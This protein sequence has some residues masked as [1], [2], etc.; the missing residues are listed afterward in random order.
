MRRLRQKPSNFPANNRGFTLVEL[1]LATLISTLVIG[2]L[3][4][5]LAFSLRVWER[6]QNQKPKDIL[7][8]L[9]LLKWQLAQF[10]PEPIALGSETEPIFRGDETSLAFATDYS[11]KAICKGVPAVVR[12][13][14]VPGE[15]A[16]YYAEVPLHPYDPDGIKRFLELRP[17]KHRGWPPFHAVPVA[18][19]SLA[20]IAK[21]S[22]SEQA[23]PWEGEE[24]VP[25]G[26]V[27]S[28]NDGSNDVATL[29]FVVPNSLF[30]RKPQSSLQPTGP[31]RLQGTGRRKLF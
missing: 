14:F 3:S 27:V 13:V 10:D 12:Y 30:H 19:F 16:V 24:S 11:T 20:Y 23:G 17:Q 22:V 5:S 1:V 6:Q 7:S 4:V 26:V 2:I 31:G 25:A 28:W 21:D 18:Q 8:L 9:N 15:Q 29:R